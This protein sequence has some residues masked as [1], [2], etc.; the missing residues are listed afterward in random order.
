[1]RN[2]VLLSCIALAL[3]VPPSPPQLP[4]ALRALRAALL[5][6]PMPPPPPPPPFAAGAGAGRRLAPF[7]DSRILLLRVGNATA[8]TGFIGQGRTDIFT[9]HEVDP[10]TGA[11]L[12]N[13]SIDRT[14]TGLGATFL[15]GGRNV[16]LLG[17]GN[18]QLSING[19]FVGWAGVRAPAGGASFSTMGASTV[20]ATHAVKWDG[21]PQRLVNLSAAAGS[22]FTCATGCYPTH[23]CPAP[24]LLEDSG[25]AYVA[26]APLA[27]DKPAAPLSLSSGVA[28]NAGAAIFPGAANCTFLKPQ[29]LA[30][31]TQLYL[32]ASGPGCAA[33]GLVAP[34]AAVPTAAMGY[35]TLLGPFGGAYGASANSSSVMP[36][37]WAI[38]GSPKF[39][40]AQIAVFVADVSPA[41]AGI[42]RWFV[43]ADFSGWVGNATPWCAVSATQMQ[44]VGTSMYYIVGGKQPF[45]VDG[46]TDTCVSA[47]FP[48]AIPHVGIA[49]TSQSQFVGISYVAVTCTA[50]FYCASGS[51]AACTPGYYCPRSSFWPTACPAGTWSSASGATSNATCAACTAGGVAPGFHCPA[52][53]TSAA[54]AACPLGFTCAGGAAAP[55]PCACY[56]SCLTAGMAVEPSP[57]WSL[58]PAV[59][60]AAGGAANG[61]AATAT[62]RDIF[63]LA[64]N[65]TVSQ[66]GGGRLLAAEG[67]TNA[68]LRMV[69][70]VT[71]MVS[72][73]AGTTGAPGYV[74]GAATAAKFHGSYGPVSVAM[75]PVSGVAYL[76]DY[77]NNKVRMLSR[78][79]STV[80]T[81]PPAFT[82]PWGLAVDP[83]GATLF[84]SNYNLGHTIVAVNVSAPAAAALLYTCG[85]TGVANAIVD[86]ACGPLIRY[87]LPS[88]L[89]LDNTG[90]IVYAADYGNCAVRSLR[91]STR[92]VGTLSGFGGCGYADGPAATAKFT[93]PQALAVDFVGNVYVTEATQARMRF[94]NLHT[95]RVGT[96]FSGAAAATTGL[97]SVASVALPQALAFRKWADNAP[98]QA[99][100]FLSTNGAW[101]N[102]IRTITCAACPA[103]FLCALGANNAPTVTPCPGSTWC[104]A[105]SY[106]PTLCPA[107][108]FA[109]VGSISPAA[110][111]LC[112]RGSYCPFN[113]SVDW[114]IPCPAGRYGASPGLQFANC[115]G[116]CTAAP[117]FACTPGSTAPSGVPCPAGHTCAG[118]AAAPASCACPSNCVV[119]SA[120]GSEPN[121]TW[122]WRVA[123]VGAA[124][125][126][127]GPTGIALNSSG[128]VLL[129]A[130]GPGN[131]LRAQPI[132]G[133]P[134]VLLAG[135]GTLSTAGGAQSADGVGT[136]TAR[137][138]NPQALDID[139]TTQDAYIFDL[140]TYVL[141][142][143]APSGRVA[144]VAGAAASLGDVDGVGS[145]ARFGQVY[146]IACA[147]FGGWAVLA[148]GFFGKLRRFSFA[149]NYSATLA[150]LVSANA[151]GVA[152][153]GGI[154]AF[155]NGVLY[156][157]SAAG[158]V[159]PLAGGTS[160]AAADGVGALAVFQ[161]LA[162]GKLLVDAG[163][164]ILFSDSTN[165]MV[166]R[167]T[168]NGTANAAKVLTI[169]GSGAI[170]QVAGYGA[171]ATF[172]SARGGAALNASTG[173][174]AFLSDS[175]LVRSLSCGF[176]P[177][178]FF[179]TPPAPF[180]AVQCPAG[181]YCPSGVSAPTPCPP[182]T[183]APAGSATAAACVPCAPG[184]FCPAGA[185]YPQPCPAGTFS[186]GVGS[187]ATAACG[188]NCS[189]APGWG[190]PAAW[191]GSAA[192]ALCP[193]GF[194]C[195][196]GA[197]GPTACACPGACASTGATF[198]PYNASTAG[199]N[200]VVAPLS[201]LAGPVGRAGGAGAV[202]TFNMPTGVGL[203]GSLLMNTSAG[204]T[205]AGAA[206]GLFVLDSIGVLVRSV[207]LP[208]GVTGDVAGAY[209]ASGLTDG[210]GA[211]AL[212]GYPN[213]VAG[214]ASGTGWVLDGSS[215]GATRLRRVSGAGN[216]ATLATTVGPL[217]GSFGLFPLPMPTGN[218]SVSFL[219]TTVSNGVAGCNIRRFNAPGNTW[220]LVAGKAGAFLCAR[221]DGGLGTG[222]FGTSLTG[223]AVDPT[224]WG[225][226]W[227]LDTH[228]LRQVSPAGD[229]ATVAGTGVAGFSDGVAATAQLSS[230]M[231]LA[232][233]TSGAVFISEVGNCRVRR[234]AAGLLTTVAGS[235]CAALAPF[236]QTGFS[237]SVRLHTPRGLAADPNSGAMY[238]VEQGA[239]TASG[240]VRTLMCALCPAGSFCPTSALEAPTACPS[241]S[242]C[243]AGAVTPTPCTP[244]FYCPAGSPA[245]VACPPGTQ[246]PASG[247]AACAPCSPGTFSTGPATGTP[248]CPNCAP[249]LQ[250]VGGAAAC[251]PC[252]AGYFCFGGTPGPFGTPCGAGNYCP[253]AAAVP[254]PCPAFGFVDATNGPANGP[255]FDVDTA[256]CLRHCFLGGP[257]ETS[258]C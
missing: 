89:A 71:G 186:G 204:A 85:S 29:L 232:V 8:R 236:T 46:T 165:R 155:A 111:S 77:G 34:S 251:A 96:L 90:E 161:S 26:L 223:V 15:S 83:S 233:D 76:S 113:A 104:A 228:S 122:I 36:T 23:A 129:V 38:L 78:D 64:W 226:M 170:G 73:L 110:C 193:R 5:A 48:Y 234:Y 197:A 2:A 162:Y 17:S 151:V 124:W 249:G 235:G 98:Y 101:G 258:Q 112:P 40:A 74:D 95:Q 100:L 225:T 253:A 184:F 120:A 37:S 57:V 205:P 118:G 9:L 68:D 190:C 230:P 201:G 239:P 147:P 55:R 180:S 18:L 218:E 185:D 160:G 210:Q 175:T 65:G 109:P 222:N 60:S 70:A 244:G 103:G 220:V 45:A 41:R 207:A 247:A 59:G 212:F 32:W 256:A 6:T 154:F 137:F 246:A 257:G 16:S 163:G 135:G 7:T 252:A 157:V 142:R 72:T 172:T 87:N 168:Q 243:P 141:R 67:Y 215:T 30:G 191:A 255:A 139:P 56:L 153:D 125:A 143:M 19:S 49:N 182:G 133:G 131:N 183:Y 146:G 211:G 169:A 106:A 69:N 219:L 27:A 128:D 50:G 203:N 14:F 13:I 1:M 241:G 145:A 181:N 254:T 35:A 199:T 187:R 200:W 119:G 130:S 209:L 97:M 136:A 58:L 194:F 86:G 198:D 152:L 10:A 164:T 51:A 82:N 94:I 217:L 115:S 171:G 123:N 33:V 221:T 173:Q 99:D 62:F 22:A 108:S 206:A 79:G 176:C 240:F 144:T 238:V 214:D 75:N 42:W 242:F 213:S 80:S 148:D 231:A 156:A 229:I 52:A 43:K 107:G 21:V 150:P 53:G 116:P 159:R 140:T 25:A 202:S 216:V 196:G 3:G 31:P 24:P 4:P 84:V 61:P 20:F 177:R 114:P 11:W 227:A 47:P 121:G 117:G 195:A 81:L 138:S 88:G 93:A 28:N 250:S 192:G 92:V 237:S 245:P 54:G 179:C 174:V 189:A 63:G 126:P 149:S 12:Q 158:V 91:I 102:F 167:I 105:G 66:Q 127:W 224:G 208:S 248:A 188:G 178:G 166:R 134:Q 39:P 132:T 44:A